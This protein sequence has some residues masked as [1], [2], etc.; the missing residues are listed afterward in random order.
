VKTEPPSRITCVVA[1]DHPAVL[2]S[3]SRVLTDAG[4]DVVAQARDGETAASEIEAHHPAVAILDMR[5]PGLDGIGITRQVT[6]QTAVIIYTAFSDSSLLLEAL[7]VGVRGF[8]LKEA[9]LEDLLRA[10]ETVA[11]GGIYIDPVLGGAL[12]GGGSADVLAKLSPR[13]REV[14]RLLADG[15]RNDEIGRRLSIAS[16]TARAHIRNAMRKLKADTRTQAVAVA[17]RQSMI[18]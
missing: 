15:C 14:L 4:Y 2:D 1:D 16:E 6:S 11:K 5:I 10:I 13:E 17:M 18:D 3:L 8:V 12:A 9:P 7:D